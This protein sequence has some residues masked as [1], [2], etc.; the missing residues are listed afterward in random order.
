MSQAAAGLSPSELAANPG[1]LEDARLQPI[2]FDEPGVLNAN[3]IVG[4]YYFKR[5]GVITEADIFRRTK[6]GAG[7]ASTDVDVL[8]N[9]ATI[10]AAVASLTTAGGDNLRARPTLKS[11]HPAYD[12]AL[13]G[14]KA[15]PGDYLEVT[16]AAEEDAP[17]GKGLSADLLVRF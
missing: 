3:D 8:L 7:V 5:R 2:R 9:G 10:L 4:R 14:I 11:D 16:I 6:S 17:K 13:G 12:A 15:E 1:V